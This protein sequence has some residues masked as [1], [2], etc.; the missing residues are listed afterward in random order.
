MW[1]YQDCI[2]MQQSESK[3]FQGSGLDIFDGF[4]HFEMEDSIHDVPSLFQNQYQNW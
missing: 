3:S 4:T 2:K 1:T